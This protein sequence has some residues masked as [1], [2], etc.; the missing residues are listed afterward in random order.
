MEKKLFF[1]QNCVELCGFDGA[2]AFEKTSEKPKD[3]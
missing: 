2:A 1:C 3:V